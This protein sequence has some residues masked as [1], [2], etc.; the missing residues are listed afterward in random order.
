MQTLIANVSGTDSDIDK[1][2]TAL[3]SRVRKKNRRR[4]SSRNKVFLQT[5]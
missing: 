4:S 2:K 1:W 3:L 5:S